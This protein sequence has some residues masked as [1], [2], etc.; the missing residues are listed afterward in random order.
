MEIAADAHA[1][2]LKVHRY[3]VS[4]PTETAK[5][6]RWRIPHMS[7]TP[8]SG[9][10]NV[11][12]TG[13]GLDGYRH[14]RD[15]LRSR[16]PPGKTAMSEMSPFQAPPDGHGEARARRLSPEELQALREDMIAASAWMKAELS[17]RRVANGAPT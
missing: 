16:L 1:V 3:R 6:L 12:I 5:S 2:R 13:K 4:E 9:S 17:R 10:K 15:S 7:I 8:A 11:Q 14:M